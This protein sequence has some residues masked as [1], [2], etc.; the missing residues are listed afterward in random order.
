VV[1]LAKILGLTRDPFSQIKHDSQSIELYAVS[2]NFVF[3]FLALFRPIAIGS[4]CILYYH[5]L[6][7]YFM[8]FF[9]LFNNKNM[10]YLRVLQ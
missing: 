10:F 8:Y 9:K 1:F 3:L 4:R 6:S 5:D 2:P 7:V